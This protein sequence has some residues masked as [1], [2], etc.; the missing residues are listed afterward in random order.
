L[1]NLPLVV[2]ASV[3]AL[4]FSS[5]GIVDL[6]SSPPTFVTYILNVKNWLN[7]LMAGMISHFPT[8][9]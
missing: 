6:S 5:Q 3:C 9:P 7:G 1:E 4:L 8:L 2:A